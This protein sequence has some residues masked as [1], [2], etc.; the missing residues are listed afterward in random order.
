MILTRPAR[1]RAG[2]SGQAGTYH[3][4]PES[5]LGRSAPAVRTVGTDVAGRAWRAMI[6]VVDTPDG[7]RSPRPQIRG[8]PRRRVLTL[9]AA[10]VAAATATPLIA[11]CTRDQQAGAPPTG[12]ASAGPPPQDQRSAARA[13]QSAQGLFVAATRLQQ[14]AQAAGSARAALARTLGAVAAVHRSTL[15]A[16]GAGQAPA[17]DAAG[18]GQPAVTSPGA[19]L[20]AERTAAAQALTDAARTSPAVAV[21]MTRIAAARAVNA[22]LVARALTVR[23]PGPL[24]A[25]AGSKPASPSL[26]PSPPPPASPVVT[27][28]SSPA[29]RPSPSPA[30][31]PGA[32][33]GAGVDALRRMVAAEHAAV[34]AYGLITARAGD[35]RRE[36]ALDCWQAHQRLRDLYQRQL[37]AA[38]AAPAPARAAYDLGSPPSTPAQAAQLAGRVEMG[39][40]EVTAAGVGALSGALRATAAAQAV[41]AARRASAWTG[42][43]VPLAG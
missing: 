30:A 31:A 42:M 22:D 11:G 17:S 29:G 5:L 20:R 33:S 3:R 13:A 35:A 10:T 14:R 25:A 39:I 41:A 32:A 9:A 6:R 28:S 38:G 40:V 16:L 18:D 23:P 27:A 19:L 43:P 34:F 36:H 2:K 37:V 24:T 8:A 1:H 7:D 4:A 26:S 21:L 12:T 15:D